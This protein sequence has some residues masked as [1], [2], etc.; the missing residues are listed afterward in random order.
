MAA[1]ASPAFGATGREVGAGA[2]AGTGASGM[3]AFEILTIWLR[4]TTRMVYPTSTATWSRFSA[5]TFPTIA[6]LSFSSRVSA[7]LLGIANASSP[8]K[9]KNFFTIVN[10]I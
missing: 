2:V 3:L 5:K 8:D 1:L 9:I 4:G 10:V 7:W 6:A